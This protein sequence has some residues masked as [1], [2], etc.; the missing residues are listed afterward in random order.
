MK[1]LRS[2]VLSLTWLVFLGMFLSVGMASCKS[3]EKAFVDGVDGYST[4]ILEEYDTYLKAD[5][6]LSEETKKIRLA[7]SAGLR[8][9]IETAKKDR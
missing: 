1:T 9:L 3:P 6:K 8:S 5:T 4:V 2:F 7:T